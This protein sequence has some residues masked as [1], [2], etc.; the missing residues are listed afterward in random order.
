MKK[1][2]L[3]IL[4]KKTSLRYWDSDDSPAK[5]EESQVEAQQSGHHMSDKG[6]GLTGVEVDPEPHSQQQGKHLTC[7]K[8]NLHRGTRKN[9]VT[10]VWNLDDSKNTD[11]WSWVKFWD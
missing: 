3:W 4:Q 5:A 1:S 11:S 10:G 7:H 8:V 2:F 9:T 6:T